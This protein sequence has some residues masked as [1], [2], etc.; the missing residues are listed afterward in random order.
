MQ[1]ANIYCK[2]TTVCVG[3]SE[4][5]IWTSK[6]DQSRKIIG[7]MHFL[8]KQLL[9]CLLTKSG[10]EYVKGHS[11]NVLQIPSKVAKMN[12]SITVAYTYI[13]RSRCSKYSSITVASRLIYIIF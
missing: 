6:E 12:R 13:K 5:K 3:N 4:S 2:R 9:F 11:I 7:L 1:N 8:S 10:R